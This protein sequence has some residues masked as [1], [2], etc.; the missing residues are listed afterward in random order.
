MGQQQLILLLLGVVI[1]GLAVVVG[2]QAF[3]ENES[4][5]AQDRYTEAGIALV[6]EV[7]A[8]YEKPR[9][10]GGAGA[11]PSQLSSVT[12]AAL[13]YAEDDADANRTGVIA[14]GTA[15][16]V[17]R[18]SVPLVQV[19]EAPLE[20]GSEIVEVAAFGPD[21]ACIVSQR[22]YHARPGWT[23]WAGGLPSNPAPAV[24]AW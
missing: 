20:T 18:T 10:F 17:Y 12:V 8:W 7:M 3:H 2:I 1:V 11:D 14:G 19:H 23:S 15:R 9:I 13:G 21:P 6:G 22:G 4:K 24:C 16:Y 5:A